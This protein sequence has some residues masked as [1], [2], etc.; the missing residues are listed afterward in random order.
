MTT[1][2]TV[3]V[4]I[5]GRNEGSRLQRCI[6]SVQ[7]ADWGDL[8]HDI[9]YVDSRSTDNSLALAQSLGVQTLVLPEGPMCAAKARN[10]GWQ[11][12]K[13]EFILFLDGDTELH[14]DF[15]NHALGALADTSLCAAWG[16]RRESNPQ[17]SFYTK[18][19]DLDWIYPAGITPYFGGDVL[20]R[21]SALAQVGGF[22]ATLNAG[23][24]PELCARLRAK[25]WKILHIDAPMTRHDLA[26]RSFKAYARRCYRSGIAYAEVTH[27]MQALGDGLWQHEARRDLVH[28]LLYVAAPL[29]LALAF[30]LH[31]LA[32][33]VLFALGLVV[34]LR[35]AWRCRERAAGDALLA[36][37]YALHSHVQKVPA[38]FGQMAWKRAHARAQHLALV[39]YKE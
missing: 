33:A 24:E 31:L 26:V 4:V 13:G 8:P 29:L 34:V 37:Q 39:D 11:A 3:S 16:H 20:V 32:G 28:G 14:P 6:A 9:W 27:R 18:V 7:Q 30:A 35:S 23:E 22:D 25:G 21:R 10:L 12:A 2:P 5:I 1:N 17:Q 15:V 19:L 38:F 36:L